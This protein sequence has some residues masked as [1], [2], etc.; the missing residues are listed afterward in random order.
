MRHAWKI[1]L[2]CLLLA[3]NATVVRARLQAQPAP[4][5]ASRTDHGGFRFAAAVT[6]E[7][8]LAFE[9]AVAAA[10]PEARRLIERVDGMVVVHVAD[11][12]P[13]SAGLMEQRADRYDV[14]VDL[15]GVTAQL[16]P[17][18]VGRV[19]LHELGHV[20]DLEVVPEQVRQELDSLVPAGWVCEEGHVGACA[21]RQERFAE[22]FAKWA[23]NDIGVDL[24]IGYKVPPP[25]VPLTT[26]G[27]PLTRL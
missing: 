26:W 5:G 13:E 12:G 6:P 7:Q 23:T 17:R 25:S 15:D 20:I 2:V 14:T 24:S 21:Q 19:V 4:A 11:P 18:G 22:S 27:L 8:R 16:G 10:R 3:A 9:T 1:A